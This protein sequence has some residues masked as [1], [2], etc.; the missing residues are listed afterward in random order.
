MAKLFN[1]AKMTTATTG[2][3]TVTLGSASNGF[4][5]F[6]AAGV[7]N[8]DVVQYV[9]EEGANFEIGTGTFSSSGNSLTRSPTESSN[10]DNAITLAGQATVSITAV[11]DD[12]NRLQHGGSDKV[13]VSSTGASVT[14]N[15]AVSGTV[16]GRDVASDG[17]KLDGIEANAKN[18]QT[19]TAGD[20][21]T[22]GGTGDVTISHSDT[23]SQASVNGSGRTYIQDITLDTYGHVTGLATATETVVNTDTDTIPNN[24]TITLTAGDALTGGGDF[25]T[26]QSSNETI[27][28]NHS[29]TSSQSSVNNSSGTVIQDVTLD[30][31]GH[32]TG[33]ASVNLDGRYY[34]ESESDTRFLRG[35]T[36]DTMSGNLTV[37]NGTSTT[38]SVK[39]DN[40]GNAIVRAGGDGQGTGVFEVTQDNGSHG[41]GISYN[42][43]GSPAFVS[44]ES[45]DHVTF[46]R[47]ASGV[48]TEVF[49]YPYSSDTVNFNST[50]TAGGVSLAKTTD[51]GNGTLTVEGTGALGGS[52]TFTANQSGNTTISISHDDTSSQASVNNSGRTYIQDIT[53]DEYGHITG[54]SSAT[55]TVTDTNTNQLTTFVV[56]DGDGTE[57]TISHGKEWKFVEGGGIDINWTDTSTGSD[58]DPF[59][60]TISHVDTSSQSS[61]DNS[62]GTVI[63]DVTL[64]GYGHVTGLASVNL[65]SRYYTETEADGRYMKKNGDSHLDMNNFSITNLNDLS[66]NDPGP[67]EGVSWL[68]G[69]L[70]KIYESPN[71]LTTNSSGNLQFVQNTTR[72]MTLDTS[73]NMYLGSNRVF[74]DNYHPNAD[75]WTT[76]RT[77][78][79]TGDVTG[80]VS[81][82]GSGNASLSTTVADD[83][84]SHS[85]Y[86]RSDADDNV[87]AHTEWQDNK[88][89]R[90]GNGADFRMWFDGTNTYFRNYAHSGGNIYF[91]GEDTEGTNHGLIYMHCDGSSPYL[92]LFQNGSERLRTLSGGVGVT[93]L[94][95][96]DVDAN[97]HNASGLHVSM[98]ADE[99]IVLS[100][101]S[102]PYIRW[103]EGTADKAYIQWNASG[104]FLDIRNQETGQFKFQST[105][106]GQASRL[107]LLR[108]DTTTVSGNELGSIN[109]GHTD[110]TPDFPTQTIS[111][112]P[113]RIIA[114]A[115]E[116]TGDGDDGA[117]LRFF[118]KATN[119]N[120]DTNSIER[121]RVDQ[122][123]TSRFYGDIE[124]NSGGASGS[125]CLQINNSSS[126]TF[127]KAIE[128]L[129]SNLTSGES[130]QFLMG[131]ALSTKNV[132]D[133]RFQYSSSGSNS[134]FMSFG[135]WD[136]DNVL[137][138]T[139]GKITTVDG[140]FNNT[141]DER[142]KEN[143]KP[144]ENALS[145]ICQLEGVSFDWKES[146]AQGQ[147][148]IAQQVEPII[149]EVVNTDADTGMKS[150]NYVG[151]IGHLV[152]AIKTQQTQIDDLKAEI[153]SMKS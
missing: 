102:N 55:E 70:W 28:F 31:Y 140:T 16:D 46:Y 103:Q 105:V 94:T 79:L 88:N 85:N 135:F 72:R 49:H 57:V 14:G 89:I 80:S 78:S 125:A 127:N 10:S 41:G 60:L 71:D 124:I 50:P 145:D 7:S 86:I 26:D 101:S 139:A 107:I 27:T 148:F 128:A 153:Q 130:E 5:T 22:G 58:G 137:K 83:S 129:N 37:D 144:I 76:A 126:S 110:G 117:R 61:V 93:G 52:G 33:L 115:T 12:L 131:R 24:A 47:I 1:R 98:G 34:T 35:N 45:S 123:G 120:K 91:Q 17:S 8:G 53:L 112:L 66:F 99:K 36:S 11:A 6:A 111:Q 39:C 118:T 48:R 51:I 19:I 109:F 97:P 42:G 4:Q 151:L 3:G 32:V 30:G 23:S 74:A 92:R 13:T 108:N 150:I 146:G 20:G 73:G 116:T 56:E 106:N 90:L 59:D 81:W 84:H 143:I 121:L 69:N 82:D 67:N 54:I 2:S 75:K 113:A 149:P 119:A 133:W 38:L 87:T 96:G 141:S 64:D 40:G 114:E 68:G 136:V 104:G 138:I 152:E 95:V 147:G 29:D 15:L 122:D 63:Q 142:L 62:G 43:D 100:G 134:N 77:L 21:L 44:G 18:D 132:A 25:T 65:D 9:I